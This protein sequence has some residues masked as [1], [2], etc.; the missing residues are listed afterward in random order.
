MCRGGGQRRLPGHLHEKM[1]YTEQGS[2]KLKDGE[3][4]VSHSEKGIYKQVKGKG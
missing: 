2:K 3:S 4:L 1:G